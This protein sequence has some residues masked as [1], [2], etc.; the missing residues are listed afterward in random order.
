MKIN[1]FARRKCGTLRDFIQVETKFRIVANRDFHSRNISRII[2]A[3]DLTDAYNSASGVSLHL[4]F[5]G[6][7]GLEF[8]SRRELSNNVKE[9]NTVPIHVIDQ[10]VQRTNDSLSPG[11]STVTPAGFFQTPHAARWSGRLPM[12]GPTSLRA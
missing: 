8:K 11:I 9:T 4:R 5:A 1:D 12:T 2:E 3:A 10:D 7:V 6:A